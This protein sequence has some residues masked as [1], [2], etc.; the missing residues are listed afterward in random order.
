MIGQTQMWRLYIYKLGDV[1]LIPL[2]AGL[3]SP[4]NII[5]RFLFVEQHSRYKQKRVK[6]EGDFDISIIFFSE[7]AKLH[8]FAI[9]KLIFLIKY[10][11]VYKYKCTRCR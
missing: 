5:Q 11:N 2:H 9:K 6:N 7:F 10:K 8:L 4:T 1:F 3:R